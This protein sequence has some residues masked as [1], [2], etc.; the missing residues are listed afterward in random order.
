MIDIEK[1]VEEKRTIVEAECTRQLELARLEIE[2]QKSL[3]KTKLEHAEAHANYVRTESA[4]E[5]QTLKEKG[6][7]LKKS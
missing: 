5:E 2:G 7:S 1:E 4:K 6:L 3:L